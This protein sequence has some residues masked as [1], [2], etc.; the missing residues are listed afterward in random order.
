MLSDTHVEQG[1]HEQDLSC[2]N[3]CAPGH[4]QEKMRTTLSD[5]RG[6]SGSDGKNLAA[7]T[8]PPLDSIPARSF[9]QFISPDHIAPA[10]A[11]PYVLSP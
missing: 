8:S 10:A 9:V 1:G 4:E 11:E 2:K 6:T 7:T 5:Q 3:C